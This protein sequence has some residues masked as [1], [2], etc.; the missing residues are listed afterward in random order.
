MTTLKPCTTKYY[1]RNA[2]RSFLTTPHSEGYEQRCLSATKTLDKI[3]EMLASA[4]E[5][6]AANNYCTFQNFAT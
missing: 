1:V 2:T 5:Q 6:T 4:H 3:S